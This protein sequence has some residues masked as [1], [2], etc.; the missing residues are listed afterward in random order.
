M[1]S[2]EQ[3]SNLR[4]KPVK[5]AFKYAIE[6]WGYQKISFSAFLSPTSLADYFSRIVYC[7]RSKSVIRTRL[8]KYFFKSKYSIQR[9]FK[10]TKYYL[11]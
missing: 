5:G 1:E 3:S 6:K 7:D 2:P 8:F 4:E 10:D 9:I 11:C